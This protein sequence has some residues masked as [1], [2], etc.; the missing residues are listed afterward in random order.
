[1]AIAEPTETAEIVRLT[2]RLMASFRRVLDSTSAAGLGPI[3]TARVL[4]VDKTLT[5]RLM[6]SLRATDPLAALHSL[7]GTTPLRQLLRAT[8]TRGAD[9][10]ALHAA[11][12]ELAAFD[13]VLQRTFGTRTHLEAVIADSLP[14][15]RRRHQDSARQAVYRGMALVKGVSIE[16][17]SLTW[18]FHPSRDRPDRVDLLVLA[19]FSGIRRLRPTASVRFI[20]SYASGQPERGARLVREFCRPSD[21]SITATRQS[22]YTTYEISTGP[23]RRDVTSDI[24]LCEYLPAAHPVRSPASGTRTFTCGDAVAHAYKRL[25]LTMLVHRGAWVG[26]D[27]ALRAYDTA[28]RGLVALPDPVRE[29]DRLEIDESVLCTDDAREALQRSPVRGH[30]DM[31]TAVVSP[32]AWEVSEFRAFHC[33]VL[34]PL[35]GA[36]IML[37]HEQGG[38]GSI[39]ADHPSDG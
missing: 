10:K 24:A 33:E 27:F 4:G 8:K 11:E 18:V 21:L 19:S 15:A 1:M 26:C 35:Y 38:V 36:H 17:A 9:Q 32:H 5:S 31:V 16:L 28:T 39:G 25:T 7:P 34:Y 30:A 2:Q 37:L 29:L 22:S 20:S 6:A 3:E 12:S 23:I 14:E 13:Q